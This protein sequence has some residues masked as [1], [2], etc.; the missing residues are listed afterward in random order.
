MKEKKE[1]HESE[2]V[3]EQKYVCPMHPDQVSDKPGNCPICG[4]KMVTIEEAEIGDMK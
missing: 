4:M 2:M 3:E 1:M